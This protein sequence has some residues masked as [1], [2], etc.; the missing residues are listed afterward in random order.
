MTE[1]I[2]E[3]QSISPEDY[4]QLMMNREQQHQTLYKVIVE[5]IGDSDLLQRFLSRG[6]T[7]EELFNETIRHTQEHEKLKEDFNA[8]QQAALQ[9]HNKNNTLEENNR[10]LDRRATFWQARSQRFEQQAM[11]QRD[12]I[13]EFLTD[14]KQSDNE[15]LKSKYST[16]FQDIWELL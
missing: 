4:K 11:Q 3:Q 1:E 2:K 16:A 15:S 5:M 7:F 13:K 9:L 14:I 6:V 12:Q 8:L 10:E